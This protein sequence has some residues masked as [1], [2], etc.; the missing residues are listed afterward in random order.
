MLL[1][2]EENNPVWKD[3][4]K[5]IRQELNEIL[6]DFQISIEHIGSTSVEGLSAKPIIDIMVGMNRESDLA[7]VPA[8]LMDKGYIYYEMYNITMPY[9][10]FFVLLTNR[11]LNSRLP[12]Q[13]RQGNEIPELLQ[14]HTL[15]KAH[16]HVLP[17]NS[18]HWQRHIAFRDYLQ[19]HPTVKEEY[20]ALKEK[21]T[22]QV[23][24]DGNEY[25]EAKNAFIK[26]VEKKALKW[27]STQLK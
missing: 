10:R 24:R 8:L 19:T 27:Q 25:N 2:F 1:P 3:R 15:R 6:S 23:W 16:I 26:V 18:S 9:R 17:R 22:K 20:Q 7:D 11:L 13:I 21:L 12:S 4:F 14:D 5:I